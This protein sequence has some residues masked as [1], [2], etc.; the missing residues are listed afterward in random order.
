MTVDL[1]QAVQILVGVIL[2]GAATTFLG[3]LPVRSKLAVLVERIRHIELSVRDV[4]IMVQHNTQRGAWRDPP[5][6]TG[7][8]RRSADDDDPDRT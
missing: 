2:G 8:R 1:S 5:V 6:D 3:L 7:Q 4:E